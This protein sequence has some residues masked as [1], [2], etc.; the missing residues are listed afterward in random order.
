VPV[1]G[2]RDYIKNSI[3]GELACMW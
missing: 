2:K 1:K 3:H